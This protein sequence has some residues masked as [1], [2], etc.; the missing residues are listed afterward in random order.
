MSTLIVGAGLVGSQIAQVLVEQGERPVL[1]DASPQP[2]ALGEIVDLS[3]CTLVEGDVLRPLTLTKA[4]LD[5]GVSAVVHTAA[6]P[7][8]T[9]GAQRDPYAA[10]QLNIMGSLNVLEAARVHGLRRVVVASSNVVSH[11]L[12]G[13]E[14]AGDSAREEA[15]PRPTT[16]YATTK[17]AI[18]N[19]G[20]N[21]ARWAGVDFAAVRYG[22]VAGPWSGRGGGGP[23]NIVRSALEAA[24][25]GREAV[26][27]A[28]PLEWVYVKDAARGTVQALQ[29]ASLASRVFNLTMGALVDAETF[30][31]ALQAVVPGARVRIQTP[32]ASAVALPSMR[33]VSDL[34]LARS[35][36][37]Y[38][39]AY[40]M[41]AAMRD[42]AG[43][44]RGRGGAAQAA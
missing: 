5:H 16:Y 37:G 4:I 6:N 38:A 15:F 36:L 29:A 9:L 10:I 18:E 40:D 7:M 33:K 3:R 39:P 27:P 42:M 44:L 13:G 17:Q 30:A 41:T 8:L 11:F 14:G 21:Y 1:F 25:A 28:D 43:W 2:E 26:V 24:L 35:V 19:I 12:A 23:S 34:S 22:A 32:A 20:L 31:G